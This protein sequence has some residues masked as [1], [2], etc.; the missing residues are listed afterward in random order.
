MDMKSI[1]ELKEMEDFEL[2]LFEVIDEKLEK[3]ITLSEGEKYINLYYRFMT[4]KDINGFCDVFYQELSLEEV[5]KL[6]KWLNQI[7]LKESGK[8]LEVALNIYCGGKKLSEDEYLD[9]NPANFNEKDG[10]LFDEI[11]EFFE[12]EEC[13]L[14]DCSELIRS[15]MKNNLN[16]F[17]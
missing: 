9:V 5:E 7:G 8:Q 3:G 17:K 11:G 13:G 15:W 14:Y 4:E 6:I 16:L 10:N 2:K 1:L 12:K